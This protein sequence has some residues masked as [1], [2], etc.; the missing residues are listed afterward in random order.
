MA[1]RLSAV[2]TI[3]S[4]IGQ[5]PV[6]SLESGNP[7]VEMAELVLDEVAMAVQSEGWYFNT[8]SSLDFPPNANGEIV[9]PEG[10]ISIDTRPYSNVPVIIRNGKLYNKGDHTFTFTESV[11]LDVLWAFDF[12]DLPISIQNYVVIRAA[13]IFAGRSVGTSEAVRFSE[14]EE[15]LAKAFALE[16]DTQQADYSIFEDG[17]NNNY[18]SGYRPVYSVLRR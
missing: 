15:I 14:K 8:E 2:N 1:T 11:T 16:F 5:A 3:I 17:S 13:N 12:E 18:Y 7:L 4:N 9:V 10:V 6:T